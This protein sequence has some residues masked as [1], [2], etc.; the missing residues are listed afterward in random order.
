MIA[1]WTRTANSISFANPIFFTAGLESRTSSRWRRPIRRALRAD[2]SRLLAAGVGAGL[3][4]V[5]LLTRIQRAKPLISPLGKVLMYVSQL[6]NKGITEG[7]VFFS[8][9]MEQFRTKL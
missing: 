2:A 3:A 8:A 7:V 9:M 5:S 1:T 4:G 6:D